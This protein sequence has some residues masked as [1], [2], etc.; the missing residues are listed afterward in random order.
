M[1]ELIPINYDN[2]EHPTVDGRELHQQLQVDTEYRH[3]FPRMCEYGFEEGHDFNPV[4]FER[5]QTEGNRQV[6]RTVQTHALSLSMAKELCMIQRTPVGKAIRLYLIQ[7]EEAWND[8]DKV[9]ERALQIAHR[10]AIEAEK[11][12]FALQTDNAVLTQQVAEMQPKV[13][14]YDTILS[15]QNAIPISVIAKDYGWSAKRMN[16]WLHEHDVQYK[17]DDVWLLKEGYA[18]Y[19]YTKTETIA[20]GDGDKRRFKVFTKWTPKGRIF[21]YQFLKDHGIFPIIEREDNRLNVWEDQE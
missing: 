4:I 3:W 19:G 13:S 21:L 17:L 12:I 14:Y 20:I 8:P 1:Q 7:V 9:M 5:V 16:K 11:R 18:D 2:P 15:C 10:R 6:T